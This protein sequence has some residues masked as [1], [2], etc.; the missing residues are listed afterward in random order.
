MRAFTLAALL[1]LGCGTAAP[2]K[3]GAAAA[4]G[5][6]T[7]T[8]GVGGRMDA[9]PVEAGL[10]TSGPCA[11]LCANPFTA[12]EEYDGQGI[13]MGN[14][15]PGSCYAITIVTQPYTAGFW[16]NT[17]DV[18]INGTTVACQGDASNDYFPVPPESD[19]D[20]CVSFGPGASPHGFV[21]I[22]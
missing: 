8:G 15:P 19:G 13:G 20:Y 18:Q 9:G 7:A 22:R 2:S 17:P 11:G 1:A 3:D 10:A 6:P 4:G 16:C 21:E 12:E 14:N 5:R